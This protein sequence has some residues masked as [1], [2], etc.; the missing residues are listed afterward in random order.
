MRKHTY[1][2]ELAPTN[3]GSQSR[4]ARF[5]MRLTC[6][7]RARTMKAFSAIRELTGMPKDKSFADVWEEQLLPAVEHILWN[8]R[9]AP[10][11]TR[12]MMLDL[13]RPLAKEDWA[14]ARYEAYKERFERGEKKSKIPCSLLPGFEV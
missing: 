5:N 4:P 7:A 3:T 6:S 10:R 9:E 1:T 13:F 2:N 14:R 11:G 12:N 8:A